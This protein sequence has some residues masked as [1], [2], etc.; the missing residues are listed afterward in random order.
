VDVG[1]HVLS[2]AHIITIV[3][4]GN[5]RTATGNGDAQR[6]G[7]L[8]ASRNRSAADS[9]RSVDRRTRES[10]IFSLASRDHTVAFAGAIALLGATSSGAATSRSA[11][12]GRS[13][14]HCH[15]LRTDREAGAPPVFTPSAAPAADRHAEHA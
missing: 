5:R 14:H 7:S 2:V 10:S 4:H 1:L 11:A 3:L 8:S 15:F 13:T 9:A 12:H 6:R